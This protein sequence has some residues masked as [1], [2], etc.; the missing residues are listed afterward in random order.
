MARQTIEE[1]QA[2]IVK[3]MYGGHFPKNPPLLRTPHNVK[4]L[5][6]EFSSILHLTE[7]V[8]VAAVERLTAQGKLEYGPYVPP[9]V[10]VYV[11]HNPDNN[12]P[13]TTRAELN[14]FINADSKNMRRLLYPNNKK[15]VEAEAEVNRLLSAPSTPNAE[16]DARRKQKE[17]ADHWGI[18]RRG[19]DVTEL[20][21]PNPVKTYVDDAANANRAAY[22]Q[23]RARLS[24]E[25]MIQNLTIASP[26]GKVDHGRTSEV[27]Q[28]LRA[29]EFKLSNGELDY[30]RIENEVGQRIRRIQ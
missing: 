2:A 25:R 16:K 12:Q 17:T 24:V 7:E 21:R 3:W 14:A 30:T 13:I 27:R 19:S 22:E 15:S 6:T 18:K 29:I 1:A 4:V 10:E 8:V 5:E 11:L 28:Q 9:P 20:D 23:N 26:S